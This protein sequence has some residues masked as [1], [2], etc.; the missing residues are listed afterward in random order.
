M[1]VLPIFQYTLKREKCLD[2][3]FQT[4]VRGPNVA[5]HSILCGLRVLQKS[6][7]ILK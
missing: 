6:I 5:I 3:I 7:N 4:L 1:A 2:L